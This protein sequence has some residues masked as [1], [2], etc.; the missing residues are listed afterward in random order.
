M[1][2]HLSYIW[3]TQWFPISLSCLLPNPHAPAPCN[4]FTITTSVDLLTHWDRDKMDAILKCIFL[5]KNTRISLEI[6]LKFVPKVRIN[7]IPALVQIMAWRLQDHKP[8]FEPNMVS[9]LTHISINQPQWVK[10]NTRADSRFAPS[11]WETSLQSNAVSHW[12]GADQ[13]STLNTSSSR[14]ERVCRFH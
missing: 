7:N 13:G 5:N 3:F 4:D 12:L 9:L 11:Q 10:S 6:S 8:L 1:V 14:R 2:K